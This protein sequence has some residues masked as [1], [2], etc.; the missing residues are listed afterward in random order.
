MISD[1][2]RW[3]DKELVKNRVV[4]FVKGKRIIRVLGFI[5]F[6]G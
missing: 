6:V 3:L 1:V 2:V 5:L 4:R